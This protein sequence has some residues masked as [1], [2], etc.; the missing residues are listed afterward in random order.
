[1]FLSCSLIAEA[2][3]A[4]AQYP[5]LSTAFVN[6]NT[7]IGDCLSRGDRILRQQGLSNVGYGE[8]DAIFGHTRTAN[9]TIS[10]VSLNGQA[11]GAMVIVSGFNQAE[12]GR[13][14]DT[15]TRGI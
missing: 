11:V 3:P 8:R 5:A 15:L 14:R 9:V 12:V 6:M 1:M 4:K 2:L 13:L 10:C 7:T